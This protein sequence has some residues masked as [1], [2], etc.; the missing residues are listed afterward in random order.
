MAT[1]NQYTNRSCTTNVHIQILREI[2]LQ[3]RHR[4]I[5]VTPRYIFC[6]EYGTV[7]RT[8]SLFFITVVHVLE[9]RKKW[10]H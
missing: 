4:L 9:P 8:A 2:G 7:S 5:S 1:R 6:M 10:T 3:S